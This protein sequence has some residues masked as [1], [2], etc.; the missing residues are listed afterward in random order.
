[1]SAHEITPARQA[2]WLAFRAV[3]ACYLGEQQRCDEILGKVI[4]AGRD[5]SSQVLAAAVEMVNTTL[6]VID[7]IKPGAG[8]EL[9][10]DIGLA[11]AEEE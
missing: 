5:A 7:D 3:E 10:A 9:L 6:Q 2:R 8:A 1:V 4:S 11:L